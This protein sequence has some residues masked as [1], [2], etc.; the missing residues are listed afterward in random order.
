MN[1]VSPEAYSQN[2]FKVENLDYN[3][4]TEIYGGL[5][6][7]EVLKIFEEVHKIRKATGLGEVSS[8]NFEGLKQVKKL[9]N[10]LGIDSRFSK[11]NNALTISRKE[12]LRKFKELVN[13]TIKRKSE[14]LASFYKRGW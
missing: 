3:M 8:K 7:E 5:P 6:R 10:V 12:N 1:F 2:G 4:T 11:K 9:L 14:K 13:F